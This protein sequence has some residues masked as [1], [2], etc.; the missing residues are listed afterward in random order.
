M[1][2]FKIKIDTGSTGFSPHREFGY[3]GFVKKNLTE[4][5]Q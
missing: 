5:V 1:E 2:Y 4:K 3:G